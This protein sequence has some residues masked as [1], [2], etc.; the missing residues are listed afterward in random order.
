MKFRSLL[1]IVFCFSKGLMSFPIHFDSSI[2]KEPIILCGV[3]TLARTLSD[4]VTIAN[5]SATFTDKVKVEL[6]VLPSGETQ[7]V[8]IN[9]VLPNFDEY[10]KKAIDALLVKIRWDVSAIKDWSKEILIV[11][12]VQICKRE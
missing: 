10:Q 5:S 8:S 12:P 2:T 9:G 6:K 4:L 11:F 3:E 7:L 1:L